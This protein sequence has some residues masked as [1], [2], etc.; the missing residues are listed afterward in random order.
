MTKTSHGKEESIQKIVAYSIYDLK[1]GGF[2]HNIV[3]KGQ[4]M[5]Y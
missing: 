4:K 3:I 1:I 5:L 2:N